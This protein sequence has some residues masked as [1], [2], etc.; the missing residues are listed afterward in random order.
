MFR[1]SHIAGTGDLLGISN[2]VYPASFAG[3]EREPL[4]INNWSKSQYCITHQS[5]TH[6]GTKYD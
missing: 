1:N 6:L 5:N 2:Q 3:Q 4:C